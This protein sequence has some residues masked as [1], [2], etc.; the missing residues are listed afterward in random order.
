MGEEKSG[1]GREEGR[2]KRRGE[3][4]E[5]SG[6]GREEWRGKRRG[7]GEEK[8]GGG[9]KNKG[10]GKEIVKNRERREEEKEGRE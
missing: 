10:E 1:G 6:G 2:G 7:A 4:E 8:S 3:G 9:E 5:R